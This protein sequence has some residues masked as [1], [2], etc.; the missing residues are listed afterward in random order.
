MTC[1]LHSKKL[2]MLTMPPMI[3]Y[4]EPKYLIRTYPCRITG[5]KAYSKHYKKSRLIE[6]D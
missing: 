3:K 4:I 5:Q 1:K 2:G 6:I